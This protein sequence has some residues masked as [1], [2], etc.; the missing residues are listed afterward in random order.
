MEP[1]AEDSEISENAVQSS[2]GDSRKDIELGSLSHA[3]RDDRNTF[4]E[5]DTSE[6]ALH[7]DEKKSLLTDTANQEASSSPGVFNEGF[8]EGTESNL[9]VEEEGSRVDAEEPLT[10]VVVVGGDSMSRENST[11]L[12][13]SEPSVES[14]LLQET[15]Q[16]WFN[17]HYY[18]AKSFSKENHRIVLIGRESLYT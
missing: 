15:Q 11:V 16:G 9:V 13:E 3:G 17:I 7:G 5:A 10:D 1:L 2:S 8:L 4:V 14:S 6:S 18:F 12:S